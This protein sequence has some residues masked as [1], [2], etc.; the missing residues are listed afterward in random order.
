M[1]IKIAQDVFGFSFIDAHIEITAC[2]IYRNTQ[3]VRIHYNVYATRTAALADPNK[4][5][6][7]SDVLVLTFADLSAALGPFY[8]ALQTKILAVFPTATAAVDV[9]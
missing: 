2:E 4:N 3:S 6:I 8:T 9:L 1:A 5:I 7:K